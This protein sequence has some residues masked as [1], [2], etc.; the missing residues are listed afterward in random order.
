MD[1]D[2]T[3]TPNILTVVIPAYNEQ[4][5]VV[6]TINEICEVLG[7][8]SIAAEIIV[9]DDGSTDQTATEAESCGVR[10]IRHSRNQGYGASLKNGILASTSEFVMITDADGTYPAQ[11]I[12]QLMEQ[13]HKMDMVVGARSLNSAGI[14]MV[15]RPAKWLLTRLAEYLAGRKIPDLNSG[16]RIFRRSELLGFLSI[17]PAGFS[18]TTTITLGML[19][20]NRRVTYVPIEYRKRLGVSKIKP[21]DFLSF[22]ILVLRTIVLFNPLKVFLPL[23]ATLFVMGMAKFV[24]DLF[25][26]DLSESAIMALLA[27]I[28]IW[29]LGLLA[30]MIGRIHLRPPE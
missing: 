26:W 2:K 6:A 1:E 21:S 4:A 8:A 9:V 3:N 19:C 13:S 5:G 12:P 29:S 16:M 20:N 14:P 7:N 25:L 23:G 18:F 10:V 22:I 17:L 28:N 24:Y 11:V 27:A 30:D 15:R